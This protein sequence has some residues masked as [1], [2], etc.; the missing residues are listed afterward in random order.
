VDGLAHPSL[1]PLAT[2]VAAA[3][4]RPLQEALR[5]AQGN[6]QEAARRV[7]VSRASFYRKLQ[8]YRLLEAAS[9]APDAPGGP[10]WPARR[11]A[12]CSTV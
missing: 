12:P 8:R 2:V 5:Q 4:R 3:E 9:C 6:C 11:S 10:S 7:G 1:V